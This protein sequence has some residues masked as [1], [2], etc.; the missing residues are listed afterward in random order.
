MRL[1][2]RR[3]LKPLFTRG[4]AGSLLDQV[5][6]QA[7]ETLLVRVVYDLVLAQLAQAASG[8]ATHQ[9][10]EASFAPAELAGTGHAYPLG[11]G[12]LRLHLGHRSLL[13]GRERCSASGFCHQTKTPNQRVPAA[14]RG[15]GRLVGGPGR[16]VK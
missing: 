13:S 6:Q 4:M 11:G 16:K 5:R 14:R 8:L 10:A 2:R 9:V 7:L 3:A 12:T 1:R 15:E